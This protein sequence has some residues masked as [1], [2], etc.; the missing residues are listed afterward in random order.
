MST[1]PSRKPDS[2]TQ[3]V[4]VISPLPFCEYQPA[5]DGLASVS[6]PRGRIAVTP[7]RTGPTPT[8]SAPA[9]SISVVWPTVTPATSV[10]AL[11]GPGVPTNGTPRSRA[12]GRVSPASAAPNAIVAAI[13]AAVRRHAV[14][15]GPWRSLLPERRHRNRHAVR[16][17]SGADAALTRVRRRGADAPRAFTLG[18]PE[19][20]P[21]HAVRGARALRVRHHALHVRSRRLLERTAETGALWQRLATDEP[22]A[23]GELRGRERRNRWAVLRLAVHVL[24]PACL[25]ARRAVL[26]RRHHGIRKVEHWNTRIEPVARRL[27]R[28]PHQPAIAA[29]QVDGE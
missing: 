11:R 6:C 3:V 4:P 9:P 27:R 16:R 21:Q 14:M 25:E 7:V 19:H 13:A 8:L 28:Q 17:R 2:S 20:E 5:N 1:G 15:T 22:E 26:P 24:L 18:G 29:G 10:M 12:R 23:A